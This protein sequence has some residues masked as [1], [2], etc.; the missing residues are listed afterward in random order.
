[1]CVKGGGEEWRE[2]GVGGGV[3]GLA[4]GPLNFPTGN[5]F[6]WRFMIVRGGGGQ[7]VGNCDL[8]VGCRVAAALT[9]TY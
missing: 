1:M 9:Y 8:Q 6:R 2:N 4:I 3:G 5:P 7:V